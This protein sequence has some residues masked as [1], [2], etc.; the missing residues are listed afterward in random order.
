[1]IVENL[2]KTLLEN[3][4]KYTY[5]YRLV[6][7]KALLPIEAPD[8]NNAI[9][10]YGIAIEVEIYAEGRI[11]VLKNHVR[12]ISSKQSKVHNLL[13]C[14]YEHTV[15]PVHLLEVVEDELDKYIVDCNEE[16]YSAV[17]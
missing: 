12:D 17:N 15:S 5:N 16:I 8:S 1:M 3:G 7:E 4:K 13:N 14:L 11:E 9:D 10:T 6:K 2:T